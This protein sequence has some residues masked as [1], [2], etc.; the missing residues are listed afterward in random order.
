MSDTADVGVLARIQRLIAEDRDDA[1]I[2]QQLV[3]GGLSRP[4]AE[5]FVQKARGRHVTRPVRIARPSAAPPTPA[6][7]ADL[8][9]TAAPA[10]AP[11]LRWFSR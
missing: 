6:A 10:R 1:S 2:V 9:T 11:W 5:R 8:P 4:A 7:P 3:D